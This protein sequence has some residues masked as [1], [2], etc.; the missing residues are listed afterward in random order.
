MNYPIAHNKLSKADA[1]FHQA[2]SAHRSG[3]F[4]EAEKWYRKALRKAPMDMETLYLLGTLCS[5]RG[6][7]EEAEKLLRKALAISP[8]RPEAW[9]SLGLTLMGLRRYE[10]AADCYRRAI[11][12]QPDYVDARSN[13]GQAYEY[14]CRYEE[15]EQELN[16]ALSLDPAHPNAHYILGLV[17]LRTDRFE[18]AAACFRRGLQRQPDMAAAH[19]DLGMVYKV[20]GRF[21]EALACFNHAARLT[22]DAFYVRNNR[23]AVLEE[24]G[25]YE[26]ALAEYEVASRLDP[27]N[28]QAKWNTS[29]LYLRQ[30]ILDRGWDAHETRSAFYHTHDRLPY[31]VW[32][33]SS[34]NG[35]T[36]LV[37][38][39]QGV[40]DEILYGS[41]IPDLIPLAGKV[42]VEC[43]RRLA[44]MFARSFPEAAV[45]GSSRLE[46]GWLTQAPRIDV[47]MPVASLP[48]FLRRTH[49][50]F[51]SKPG[52][53]MADPARV[54]HWKKRLALLGNGL[55]V[56]ICWRSSL[57]IGERGKY[58]SELTQWKDIFGVPGV[59]FVKLQY[60]ECEEEL[61][62]AE[63]K[64]GVNIERFPELDQK[65]EL[66][67]TAALISGLDLVITAATAVS[68]LAG[69]LGVKVFRLNEYGKP[70]DMLG[71]SGS[72]W[73]PRM[74]MFGQLRVGDWDTPLALIGDELKGMAA[75]ME[76]SVREVDVAGGA[77]V[78]V[79]GS[80]EDMAAYVLQEKQGW[81]DDA[82]R[83][84]IRLAGEDGRVVDVGA[85]VGAYAL[86]IAACMKHGKV[87][88]YP[89]TSQETNLLVKSRSR[90]RLEAGLDIEIA[91]PAFSL[92]EQLNRHGLENIDLLRISPSFRGADILRTGER[93]FSIN[94][95][96]LM[97]PVG[98]RAGL[99]AETVEWLSSHGFAL[100][101]FVPGLE[102]LTPYV[103]PD[104]LDAFST[105]LFA[106]R[107]DRVSVLEQRG[108]LVTQ[109]GVLS[110]LPGV[111]HALWQSG[112]RNM[113]YATRHVDS[114]VA[115]ADKPAEWE[116]Y[117][118]ALN[119]YAV[120]HS[121]RPA[122]E[123]L[124]SLETAQAVL[125]TLI[126]THAT[127][128]RLLSLCRILVELGQRESAVGLLNRV[129]EILD[130]SPLQSLNEPLLALSDEF[131]AMDA[132]DRHAQW[133]V[134]MVLKH[135]EDL[136]AFSDYFTG[137]EA[138]PVLE[139]IERLGFA[140]SDI[141]RRITL[142]RTRF[143]C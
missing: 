87:W 77:R 81:F 121:G 93:F 40:G 75:G 36:I 113:A 32:D 47:Q 78:V 31:P 13:L 62:E 22:P 21:E 134:A 20:W 139:E 104:Q 135:R 41:C 52:Y 7:L 67:E 79:S 43:D 18:E 66:D 88:A 108:V 141:A 115:L 8:D 19:S 10:E 102:L 143:G 109:T 91:D 85:G 12:I 80:P 124:A 16:R 45:F 23:G 112:L 132:G 15:A 128:P 34:L 117:W 72:P 140:T 50:S 51:P 101:R 116:V 120:A 61:R 63:A 70:M 55:K 69:A 39:E 94:S 98:G 1:Y 49:D 2:F 44:P 60:D 46:V 118:M 58:Y 5:Q 24:L 103:S 73:H 97:L 131:A 6:R 53:L 82:F 9:N 142:I 127:L 30:G 138:R 137:Q 37:M 48:R 28:L 126:R 76:S 74:A 3:D 17:K 123:R 25:R 100:F 136:R 130:G 38:A 92:D 65:N 110:N 129:C 57:R 99:D 107:Q 27:T 64:F 71:T 68:E 89:Q 14:M 33:G 106:A 42:V 114:W 133:I 90:N 83:F 11:A 95:P 125:V 86:P 56:G 122:S 96:L 84:V 59:H 35:K 29:Y 54:E 111:Q 4:E 105:I 119:L 26:E